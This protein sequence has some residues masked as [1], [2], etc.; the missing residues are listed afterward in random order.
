VLM[1]WI[2]LMSSGWG[3]AAGHRLATAVAWAHPVADARWA[4]AAVLRDA[5]PGLSEQWGPAYGGLSR[6]PSFHRR[7]ACPFPGSACSGGPGPVVAAKR[8]PL[9]SQLGRHQARLVLI[10]H[11]AAHVLRC[12]RGKR[13][14]PSWVPSS[15]VAT[16]VQ[17]L[18]SSRH[19]PF[20]LPGGLA[21]PVAGVLRGGGGTD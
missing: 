12:A 20:Y 16:L 18:A 7:A 10:S 8:L 14:A 9:V 1:A 2:R 5:P 3:R 11:Y 19:P 17:L 15:A 6:P 13:A 4:I 21:A